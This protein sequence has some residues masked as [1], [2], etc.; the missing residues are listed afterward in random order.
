MKDIFHQGVLA[1]TA[2]SR[3]SRLGDIY[4]APSGI[5]VGTILHETLHLFTGMNDTAL[6]QALGVSCSG[7][8]CITVALEQNGCK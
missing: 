2:L 5:Q 6:K 4:F 7:S 1:A 8:H 3:R